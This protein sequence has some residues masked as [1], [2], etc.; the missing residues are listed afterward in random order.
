[1]PQVGLRGLGGEMGGGLETGSGV[2]GPRLGRSWEKRPGTG[3]A[4]AVGVLR[5]GVEQGLESLEWASGDVV[6][7]G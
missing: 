2:R 6:G 1:M 3:L 7:C 5:R 4:G